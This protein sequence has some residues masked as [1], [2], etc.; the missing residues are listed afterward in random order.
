M[1]KEDSQGM[2]QH[3]TTLMALPRQDVRTNTK[4]VARHLQVSPFTKSGGVLG[5]TG[6][7]EEIE[8]NDPTVHYFGGCCLKSKTSNVKDP[9]LTLNG[10]Q[11]TSILQEFVA[12]SIGA[13]PLKQELLQVPKVSTRR[14]CCLPDYVR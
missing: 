13:R 4:G 12:A 3:P 10:A 11:L 14:W 7:M 2:Q 1:L 6:A 9:H 8:K 5:C